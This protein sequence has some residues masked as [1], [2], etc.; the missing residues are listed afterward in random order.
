MLP[1]IINRY[2][3]VLL[4]SI[5]WITT[6]CA[7]I[8][9]EPIEKTDVVHP[10]TNNT[11]ATIEVKQKDQTIEAYL[12]EF[13]NL[14][15]TKNW[16]GLAD[17]TDFPIVIRGELDDEGSVNLDRKIF[18]KFIGEFFQEEV[19]LTS[20]DE[21]VPS[22]YRDL[23]VKPIEKPIINK[24]IVEL[25]GFEFLKKGQNWKLKQITTYVHIVEKFMELNSE[26]F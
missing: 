5:L 8:T 1:A 18:V 7:K 10:Q 11:S 3:A 26:Y 20:N 4:A 24:D 6:G 23:M 2:I 19:Y 14:L 17:I 16:D 21:L 25:H 13:S 12:T 15:K 22:T 9:E